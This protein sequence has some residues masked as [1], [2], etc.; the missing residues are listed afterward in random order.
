MKSKM[1]LLITGCFAVLLTSCLGDNSDDDSYYEVDKNCQI[2]G[3]SLSSDSVAGLSDVKFTI[4]QLNGHIMNLDSMPFG[5][6]IEKVICKVEYGSY[7][8]KLEVIPSATGDTIDWNTEDSLDFSKPVKFIT[9]SYDGSVKRVYQAEINIHQ[10]VPDSIV[11]HQY[12]TS[13]LPDK[14][15]NQKVISFNDGN[16]D[17]Y[18][19]Y[20]QLSDNSAYRLYRSMQSDALTWEELSLTGLPDTGVLFSQITAFNDLYYV[21]TEEGSLYSSADAADWQLVEETPK[22]KTLLGHV[23]A[24]TNQPAVLA[25]IVE[26]ENGFVFAAMDGEGQWERGESVPS[27]FPTE[28]FS[29]VSIYLMYTSRAIVVGGKSSDGQLQNVSWATMNALDWAKQTDSDGNYFSKR[30]GAM[31]ACY[32]NMFYLIGGI[33]ESGV[34]L[35]DIYRSLDYGVTWNYIDSLVVLPASYQARGF[36]SLLVDKDNYLM[37]FG[38]KSTMGG[39]DL[40]DI[41]KGRINRLGFERQ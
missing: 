33:D 25:T 8:A 38:G 22:V 28:G 26:D 21:V 6:E 3:F 20:A 4:D 41:W 16:T 1:F 31:L 12:T 5:T 23:D 24:S 13:M 9:S 15:V 11:W 36:A 18:Y 7:V 30:Q 32:D 40:N 17:Y 37:I 27:N 39:Q 19:M 35:K 14:P 34:P 2:T 29:S 10:V